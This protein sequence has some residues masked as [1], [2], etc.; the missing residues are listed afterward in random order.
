MGSPSSNNSIER[1]Q[2][3]TLLRATIKCLG[4]QLLPQVKQL[5]T[6]ACASHAQ[7]TW[8]NYEIEKEAVKTY[9]RQLESCIKA[10]RK[11]DLDSQKFDRQLSHLSQTFVELNSVATT[12]C[13][14]FTK[15]RKRRRP[16]SL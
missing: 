5:Y 9:I 13:I 7:Q 3:E 11:L 6:K 4:N 1:A 12:A 8:G 15:A 10:I 2:R 16:V 14:E